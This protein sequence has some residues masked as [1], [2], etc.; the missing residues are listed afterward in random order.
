MGKKILAIAMIIVTI[1]G[2]FT[3]II[4]ENSLFVS[5]AEEVMKTDDNFQYKVNN[6]EE[7]NITKYI[8]TD[9]EVDVPSKIDGKPVTSIGNY[10]FYT[11]QNLTNITI[12]DSVIKI[13]D[14]AF[15]C[16]FNLKNI[17]IPDSV[18]SIG[19]SA[20]YDCDSLTNISIPDSVTSIRKNTFKNC[21]NLINITIP[22]SVKNIE[23]Y[24][25][26]SCSSLKNIIIP[27]SV[28]NIGT[29]AFY[30]CEILTSIKV[31]KYNKNYVDEDG[32]LF[33]KD[34]SVL[35][36][37]PQGKSREL[38]YKIPDTV[39][40]IGDYAFSCASHLTNISIPNS[41]TNIGVNAFDH[42][43]CLQ[44]IKIPNSVT[45][46]KE[47]TFSYCGSLEITIPRSVITIEDG[48]FNYCLVTIYG[49]KDSYAETFAKNSSF[50]FKK[51]EEL[52]QKL[53]ITSFTADKVSPQ[54]RGT[55]ITLTANATGQGALQYKFIV[56]DNETENWY[57][58]RDFEESNTFIWKTNNTGN[59]TLYVYVKDENGKVKR[60]S[61]SY[62]VKKNLIDSEDSKSKYSMIINNLQGSALEVIL[63]AEV[64]SEEDLQYRFLFKDNEENENIIKEFSISN[65]IA[66]I[67]PTIKNKEIYVE[68]KDKYGNIFSKKIGEI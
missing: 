12:P 28:T 37:Y 5:A 63:K 2:A 39:K 65:S 21:K 38:S 10:A 67:T 41:V 57:K 20:F 40:R 51:I 54:I 16:C 9:I 18:T 52:E 66:W 61:M 56:R 46:I 17:T 3:R 11:C 43:V 59:K 49:Y 26:E 4:P 48:A 34:K 68:V 8:G 62:I 19:I 50:E 42:C 27:S 53:E 44:S 60:E 58:L 55:S 33:N 6:N 7:V 64:E 35:V 47:Y 30:D 45:T 22:N 24:A 1:T 25:F 15:S 13:G 32:V 36:R 14:Y 31:Y 23:E 29:C